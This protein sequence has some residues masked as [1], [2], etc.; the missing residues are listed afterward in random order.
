MTTEISIH[1]VPIENFV[2]LSSVM[3]SL[4]VWYRKHNCMFYYSCQIDLTNSHKVVLF[5]EDQV[6]KH[7]ELAH[8]EDGDSI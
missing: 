1:D 8:A 4:R 2:R 5:S 7:P 3:R 6:E